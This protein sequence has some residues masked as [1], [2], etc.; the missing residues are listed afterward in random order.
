MLNELNES[1]KPN[2]VDGGYKIPE[3]ITKKISQ[4]QYINE[5][6]LRS[7]I[8]RINNKAFNEH[9]SKYFYDINKFI[10]KYNENKCP[11]VAEEI[12]NILKNIIKDKKYQLLALPDE[13]LKSLKKMLDDSIDSVNYIDDILKIIE[14]LNKE[15]VEKRKNLDRCYKSDL[16]RINKYIIKHH[17]SKNQKYKRILRDYITTIAERTVIDKESYE[18]FGELVLLIIKNILKK[19]KFS[20]YTYRDEFYSD[21]TDKIFRYIK[22]FNHKLISEISNQPVNAFS[23]ISQ[24]VHNSILFIINTNK[25]ESELRQTYLGNYDNADETHNYSKYQTPQSNIELELGEVK[26]GKLIEEIKKIICKDELYDN[27]TFIYP[28]NYNISL[29]EY[30]DFHKFKEDISSTISI[31]RNKNE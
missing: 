11:E 1:K 25:N 24:Y 28:K 2:D 20:G 5:T 27:Y 8:I 17:K 13:D 19:P 21:S 3:N 9:L 7:L 14:P 12:V 29:D 18:R 31:I 15:L 26:S 4:N 23:Y 22:N 16:T 10:E 6:E 30:K